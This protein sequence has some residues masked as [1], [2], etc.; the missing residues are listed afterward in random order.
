MMQRQQSQPKLET[1]FPTWKLW[2]PRIKNTAFTIYKYVYCEL[3]IN[4]YFYEII[5]LFIFGVSHH[6]LLQNSV[7]TLCQPICL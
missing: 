2:L 1:I 5:Y 3:S 4:Y 6:A 7:S